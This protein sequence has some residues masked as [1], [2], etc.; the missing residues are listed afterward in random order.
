MSAAKTERLLNLVICLLSTHRPLTR[1]HIR[2]AIPQYAQQPETAVFERM[3][4]RDKEELRDLGVPLEVSPADPLFGDEL[5]YRVNRAEYALAPVQ[6]APD[7][8]AALVLA[9]RLW[10]QASFAGPAAR[11][12]LKLSSLGLGH[13]AAPPLP[14]EPSLGPPEPAFAPLWAAVRDQTPVT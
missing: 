5:G 4:E 11:A 12:L 7:E 1:E 13:D 6:F 2:Q 10:Q 8:R 9:A 3:F 14:I